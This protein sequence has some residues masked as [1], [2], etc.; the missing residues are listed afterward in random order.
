MPVAERFKAWIYGCPLV[1]I[2]GSNPAGVMDVSPSLVSVVCCQVEDSASG[3]TLVQR[4]PTECCMSE[5]DRVALTTRT[6][7]PT[8]GCRVIKKCVLCKVHRKRCIS[9]TK[10]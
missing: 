5:C 4:S 10:K 6:P 7:R 8:R 1:D 9:V 3:R 2:A